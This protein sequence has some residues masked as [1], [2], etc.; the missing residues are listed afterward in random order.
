VAVQTDTSGRYEMSLTARQPG[1]ALRIEHPGYESGLYEVSLSV[2][3]VSFF[4]SRLHPVRVI[5]AD[6]SFQVSFKGDD[7]ICGFDGEWVCQRVRIRSAEEG[8]L[9][10][11]IDPPPVA[12]GINTAT[13]SV[14]GRE[15]RRLEFRV[16]AGAENAID[17][18]AWWNSLWPLVLT[19][20]T[21]LD[22]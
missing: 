20:H 18:Y 9:V 13:L 17:V 14:D 15:G 10:V 16:S 5:Q 3:R 4:R 8:S 6:E 21:R 12:G 11:S 19:I 2:D 1:A 22:R 7:P